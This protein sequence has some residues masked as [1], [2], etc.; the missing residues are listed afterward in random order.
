MNNANEV[1]KWILCEAK[2]QGIFMTHMKLQKLLYYAQSYFI[3]MTGSPLFYNRIEAWEHGPVVPDVYRTYSKYG[4]EIISDV[5]EKEIPEEFYNIIS[6]LIKDKGYFSA[7]ELR[8]MTHEEKPWLIAHSNSDSN[9]I[10]TEMLNETFTPDFWTSDEED[11]Y[12]PSFDS[13]DDEEK[14]FLSKLTPEERNAIANS[15]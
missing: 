13:L 9:L 6:N 1:A 11:E 15:R 4:N 8:N 7:L 3:G 2:R 5:D 14:Y 12:Q 10:T